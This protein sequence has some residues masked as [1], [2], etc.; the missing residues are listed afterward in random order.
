MR[1][2]R[3]AV[4]AAAQASD[5]RQW[6]LR[7]QFRALEADL[8]YISTIY[9]LTLH[10]PFL[11]IFLK[12]QTETVKAKVVKATEKS[13]SNDDEE[14]SAAFDQTLVDLED[15]EDLEELTAARGSKDEE[16][17]GSLP[18]DADVDAEDLR[19]REKIRGKNEKYSKSESGKLE[20][21]WPR[22]ATRQR[23]SKTSDKKINTVSILPVERV[24]VSQSELW[25]RRPLGGGREKPLAPE[26]PRMI[27][28]DP[29]EKFGAKQL[30]RKRT[31]TIFY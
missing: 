22:K 13:F 28:S 9:I 5:P 19:P 4:A 15:L 20:D 1:R 30:K 25:P 7:R 21:L 23:D 8:F 6:I 18:P 29:N 16:Y 10:L 3:R 26:S 11:N 27:L 12:I 24:E 17:S 2:I 14:S 31:S